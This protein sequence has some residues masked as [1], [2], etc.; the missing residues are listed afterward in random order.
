MRIKMR[1]LITVLAAGFLVSTTAFAAGE[2]SATAPVADTTAPAA[3]A[4]AVTAPAAKST[5]KETKKS[6][7]GK[8]ESKK[9]QGGVGTDSA[10]SQ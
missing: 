10:S 5:S 9:A 7:A 1:K 2:Y 3:T 8:H 6:H 4:P